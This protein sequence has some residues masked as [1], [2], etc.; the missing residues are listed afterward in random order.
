MGNSTK[1]GFTLIELLVVIAI[2][3]LL[4]AILFPVFGRA[5]ENARRAACQSNFKQLGL[6]LMQYI[7]DNDEFLP[8]QAQGSVTSAS[9]MALFADPVAQPQMNWGRGLGIYTNNY[10]VFV[11]PSSTLHPTTPPVGD[12]E[13]SYY[14]NGVL[15]GRSLPQLFQPATLIVMQ[16]ATTDS[17]TTFMRPLDNTADGIENYTAW[18]ATNYSDIHFGGSNYL[19][20]DGHVKFRPQSN[21]CAE[22][23]GLSSTACGPVATGTTALRDAT[24]VG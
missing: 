6:A 13:T 2:I 8:L 22:E 5:R 24:E 1:R 15:V 20:Q 18:L 9:N 4:A 23:Y 10:Q 16:E 7:Q 11:C 12:S 3:S 17:D 19:Y 21:V 14:F